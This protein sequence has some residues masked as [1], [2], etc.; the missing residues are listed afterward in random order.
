MWSA[1][2]IALSRSASRRSY[3]ARSG[4]VAGPVNWFVLLS[5]VSEPPSGWDDLR[6]LFIGG[7]W[8]G[9]NDLVRVYLRSLQDLCPNVYEFSTEEHRD[10]LDCKGRPYDYGTHGPVYLRKGSLDSVL[11]TFSPH[12]ILCC[13]GGLSFVPHE[14][15]SLRKSYCLAGMALSDP[16]VFEPSTQYIAG[17]FDAYFTNSLKAAAWYR[18]IGANVTWLPFACYPKYH[19]RLPRAPEFAC[20]VMFLGQAR[21][22]R[23]ALVRRVSAGF[24]T[25]VFGTSWDAFDVSNEGILPPDEI[26]PAVN[27][28]SVCVDFARN[29]AGEYMVKY[30]IFEFA[31]CGAVTF[32]ETFPE[33]SLHFSY[34]KEILGY[35]TED[36]L[37]GHI[38]ACIADPAY[39]SRIGENAYQRS[40]SEHT[41]AHR[42]QTLLGRCGA[43]LPMR[44]GS[45]G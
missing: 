35:S 6:I 5:H 27:S 33:L 17:N 45:E 7:Y 11:R 13:A 8:M 15:F 31:G 14:A 39:R 42:W 43:Y 19:R 20:D 12:L 23:V 10:V 34:G 28:A 24:R 37:L 41:F 38:R 22:D 9:D 21:P 3:L 40:R 16:D 26:V 25:R 32:T 36:E 4:R 44:N 1:C 18:D 30:R 2:Q 29:L